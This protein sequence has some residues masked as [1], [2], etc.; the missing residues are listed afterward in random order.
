MDPSP[1]AYGIH[2]ESHPAVGESTEVLDRLQ[3]MWLGELSFRPWCAVPDADPSG[4]GPVAA[5]PQPEFGYPGAAVTRAW[6]IG[7]C[8]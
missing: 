7:R 4:A 3:R 5:A 8:S 1:A 6:L 2:V